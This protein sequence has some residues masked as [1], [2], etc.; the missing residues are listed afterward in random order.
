LAN[1]SCVIVKYANDTRYSI[2]EV[3]THDRL[4]SIYFSKQILFD[5]YSTSLPAIP[6]V[7][8]NSIRKQLLNYE[9]IA[10]DEGQFVFIYFTYFKNIFMLFFQFPDTVTISEEL[11]NLGKVV[12]VAALDGDY[13]REVAI[14]LFFI[15]IRQKI[16]S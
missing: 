9:V 15:L 11:A 10:I 7:S 3:E 5:Y 16:M 2:D 1:Y 14:L 6:A 13:K 4:I 12:I 8:L